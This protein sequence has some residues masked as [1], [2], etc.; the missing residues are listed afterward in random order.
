MRSLLPAISQTAGFS[1]LLVTLSQCIYA[2]IKAYYGGL[3]FSTPLLNF[4]Y[5]LSHYFT[6]CFANPFTSDVNSSQVSSLSDLLV[7]QRHTECDCKRSPLSFHLERQDVLS[8]SLGGLCPDPPCAVLLGTAVPLPLSGGTMSYSILTLPVLGDSC[9]PAFDP[10]PT[11]GGVVVA[12]WSAM[13][14]VLSSWDCELTVAPV[15]FAPDCTPM[16][17]F[18]SLGHT[19]FHF[20]IG[21]CHCEAPLIKLLCDNVRYMISYR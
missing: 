15:R 17:L 2:L 4:P 20:A 6:E 16:L 7:R 19:T 8:C 12:S 1:L 9:A 18:D 3:H 10:P 13:L 5:C 21:C 14:L 11:G